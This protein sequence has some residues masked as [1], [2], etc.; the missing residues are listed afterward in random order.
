MK[1]KF[2]LG[3]LVVASLPILGTCV[4]SLVNL[5][6][7]TYI[8]QPLV[9]GITQWL[10]IRYAAP[11]V[12]N[13]RF[14][15]PRDPPSIPTPQ[16]ANKHGKFC[17]KTG[18][19]PNRTMTSEDCLFLDVYA[20]SNATAD[21]K[22]PVFF[23]IQG[24]GF[25]GNSN[26]NL[27]GTG[28]VMA[29]QNSIV[30]VTFNYRVGPYGF[31]TDGKNVTANNGLRDQRKALE[32]VQKNIAQFGGDAGHV[33]LG[34]SSAGAAS[35]SLHMI[36]YGGKD[37]GLFH[38]AAAE[39]VSFATA[40]TV[41]ESQYQF[42]NF[43]T[44]LGCEGSDPLACLRSKSSKKLQAQNLNI[45]Y[46]GSANKPLYMW[47][48]VIDND[49]LSE[50]PYVAFDRGNF[51]RV[52]VIIGDDTNGGTT[53]VPSTTSTRGQ[54]NQ[55]LKDQFPYLTL[56]QLSKLNDLYPN[57]D[58][59]DCPNE[60]CWW[61]QASNVYGEMRYMCPGLFISAAVT[62]YGVN[63][64]FAYRW[65][66]E[67]AAQMS[68]GLGVPHTV[69]INALFGPFNVQSTPPASYFPNGTNAHAVP[70]IQGYWTSFIKTYDPNRKRCCGSAVWKRW[71]DCT[72][73][74]LRFDSGG[75]TTME[76]IDDGLKKR[77]EYLHSI[78]VGLQQ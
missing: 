13:L 46:P 35:I 76:P 33:V 45:P 47:N 30:V 39:S 10:G 61:R 62:R 56:Q 48:P 12:G 42:D 18:D 19:R 44:R 26:P 63:A 3:T 37:M 67:D 24:G 55:F 50:I 9:S 34:G 54:S 72:K 25:N 74:R 6:Y 70:V 22:L 1:A 40:L 4:N 71:D 14:E 43:V 36:A 57:P 23:F 28:L 17:L 38:A 59:G 7:S 68:T 27:N 73:E 8:G 60:G 53:F 75:R 69:E 11:P 15:P 65:N 49:L 78:G 20:P 2:A 32:W 77:C 58:Q 5:T 41:K 16:Q 51:V 29:S 52:P 31:L 64:S 66:V 21:S